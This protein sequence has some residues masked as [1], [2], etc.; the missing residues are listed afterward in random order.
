MVAIIRRYGWIGSVL[1]GTFE[2]LM[3]RDNVAAVEP[4]KQIE[5][6]ELEGGRCVRRVD[7]SRGEPTTPPNFSPDHVAPAS[8]RLSLCAFR[9][10]FHFGKLVSTSRSRPVA[11]GT[12]CPL[13]GKE[14]HGYGL[15]GRIADVSS[16]CVKIV[17][18]S[19]RNGK[20]LNANEITLL[21]SLDAASGWRVRGIR[22]P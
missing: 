15:W 19:V 7:D 14:F 4:A 17:D 5:C 6:L 3:E 12:A 18:T 11:V 1:T 16:H 8:A 9:C 13:Y 2:T 21:H 22:C 10:P 20:R